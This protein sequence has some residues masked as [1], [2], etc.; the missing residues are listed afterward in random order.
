MATWCIPHRWGGFIGILWYPPPPKKMIPSG[1]DYSYWKWPFIVD[2][3]IKNGSFHSYVKLP[4]GKSGMWPWMTLVY[5]LM[6]CFDISKH[7]ERNL[8]SGRWASLP[9]WGPGM[10]PA[11]PKAFFKRNW[12]VKK[13]SCSYGNHLYS[14]RS[15]RIIFNNLSS[16]I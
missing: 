13:W 6:F 2:F 1:Y 3:P 8:L 9:T 11:S 14:C 16:S 12:V 4:E 5:H 10:Q 15:C 7:R